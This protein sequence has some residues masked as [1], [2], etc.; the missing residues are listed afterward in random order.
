ELLHVVHCIDTEGPLHESLAAT[1]ERVEAMCGQ[2]FEPTRANLEALQAGRVDLGG[3]EAAVSVALAPQ[4][5]AYNDDWGKIDA[6]LDELLSP[7]YRQR[8]ADPA[9]RPWTYNWFCVD[10]V[11]YTSNPRRRDMGYHNVFDHY[12][13]RLA[14]SD[15]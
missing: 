9:G 6:M 7:A 5:L 11:G 10:H 12:R 2:R 14:G 4:L 3:R 15:A 13:E 1:F 8:H